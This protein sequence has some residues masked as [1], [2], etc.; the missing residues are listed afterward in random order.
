MTTFPEY[1][2]DWTD[3]D[4]VKITEIANELR[5]SVVDLLGV[6]WVESG[7]RANAQH[8]R[9]PATGLIQWEP[10]ARGLY[11]GLSRYLF[12]SLGVTGQLPYVREWFLPHRGKLTNAARI[13][14]A[15]FLPAFI[16]ESVDSNY[17]MADTDGRLA[18]AFRANPI[19]DRL[20]NGDGKI[21]VWE[22]AN[23]IRHEAH[24]GRWEELMRRVHADPISFAPT[25]PAT[26]IPMQEEALRD[27]TELQK[28]LATL[29]YNPGPS[30]GILGPRTRAALT[31]FQS[32]HGLPT[33][34][35][36]GYLTRGRIRSELTGRG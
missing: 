10:D 20:G 16:D 9:G 3:D 32:A 14:T 11:H 29:G 34:G 4:C 19:F 7:C 30:D 8:P 35:E 1:T 25:I 12:A 23:A 22:L 2:R 13:Y 6:M 33:D 15:V 21:Q 31:A 27:I 36:P 26:P 24:G 17:V 5:C 28:A 18:W